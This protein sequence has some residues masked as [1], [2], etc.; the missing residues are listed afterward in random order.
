MYV[1]RRKLRNIKTQRFRAILQAVTQA[2]SRPV[3]DRHEV[4]ADHADT[5][6]GEITNRLLIGFDSCVP[7]RAAFLDISMDRHGLNDGPPKTRVFNLSF[8]LSNITHGPDVA[9]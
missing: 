3:D 5:D 4:V 6:F 2:R 9:R 8:A 7:V 1:I